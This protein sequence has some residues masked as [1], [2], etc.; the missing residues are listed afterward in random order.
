MS[1]QKPLTVLYALLHEAIPDITIYK[2]AVI[3]DKNNTPETFIQISETGNSPKVL[4]DG[5]I[6]MR[7]AQCDI[8]VVSKS[9][10]ANSSDAFNTLIEKIVE[11]LWDNDIHYEYNNLG[12]DLSSSLAQGVFSINFEVVRAAYG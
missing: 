4:G 10:G 2:N 9:K 5:K 8:L 11:T 12:Y 1:A 3:D 7:I 6:L